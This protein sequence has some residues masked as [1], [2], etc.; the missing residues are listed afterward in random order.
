MFSEILGF[1]YNCFNKKCFISTVVLKTIRIMGLQAMY[2]LYDIAWAA[3]LWTD[4]LNFNNSNFVSFF[5][6]KSSSK[7]NQISDHSG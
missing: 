7:S 1:S 2:I 3:Q 6:R 4:W 5:P